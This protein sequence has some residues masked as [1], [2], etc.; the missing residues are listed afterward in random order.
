MADKIKLEINKRT[1]IIAGIIIL[2]IAGI[3]LFGDK[4]SA[5]LIEERYNSIQNPTAKALYYTQSEKLTKEVPERLIELDEK[6]IGCFGPSRI[7]QMSDDEKL[8][9]QCCGA[10]KDI[11][12]YDLQIE[13]LDAF[14]G[15]H[16]ESNPGVIDL[17]PGDPYDVPISL[18]KQLTAYDSE[19]KLNQE[20][21]KVYD[22]A[23]KNSHHGG[24]CCCK[25]WKWYMMSGLAKKLIFAYGFASG[26]IAELWDI[27]SSCGHDDDTNMVQH[28]EKREKHT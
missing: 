12:S 7:M 1:L 21:Q 18:A 14:I 2:F 6:V 19:I 17:I 9:G 10:L 15:M 3:L 20:Q 28:Y 5:N 25:C 22:E 8:G 24:P 26:D 23:I 11:K 16:E 27:S 13:I 4:T